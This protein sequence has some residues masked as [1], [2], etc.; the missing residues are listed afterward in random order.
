MAEMVV[1]AVAVG[2]ALCKPHKPV[3][4]YLRA[5]ARTMTVRSLKSVGKIGAILPHGPPQKLPM[6]PHEMDEMDN[7]EKYSLFVTRME[8]EV[9]SL[10]ALEP[11]SSP[12]VLKAQ[13]LFRGMP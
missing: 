5:G 1:G 11:R 6:A 8:R 2:D 3:R 4:L 10:M 9:V 7:D 12:V 13:S